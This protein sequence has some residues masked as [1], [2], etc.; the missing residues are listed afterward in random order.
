MELGNPKNVHR[1][2]RTCRADA[3]LRRLNLRVGSLLLPGVLPPLPVNNVKYVEQGKR[4]YSSPRLIDVLVYRYREQDDY[5]ERS[6]GF[7]SL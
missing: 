2:C 7:I 1:P 3:V 5:T 6:Q 4:C